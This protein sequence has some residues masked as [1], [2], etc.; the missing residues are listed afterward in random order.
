MREPSIVFL[1]S[2][3]EALFIFIL[4]VGDLY[5]WQPLGYFLPV[6]TPRT[7][8]LCFPLMNP[9]VLRVGHNSFGEISEREQL[10]DDNKTTRERSHFQA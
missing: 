5:L 10:P 8:L 7:F 3:Q 1:G 2:L 9:A 4:S 6:Q